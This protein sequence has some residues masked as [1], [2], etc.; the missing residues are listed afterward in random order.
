LIHPGIEEFTMVNEAELRAAL[1]QIK[2]AGL[3]LLVH[4]ELPGP[5]E[6]AAQELANADWRV[7]ETFL[8]SRPDEAELAAIDLLLNLCREFEC[9]IHV[10]HLSTARALERLRDAKRGGL[11]ITVETCPHYLHLAAEEIAEGATQF[12]CA[13]P[14][15]RR[16]NREALWQGL[17][18]GVIDLVA[19]DHSPCPPPMKQLDRGDFRSAWGGIPGVSLAL[20]I[21]WTEARSRGFGLTDVAR[22]M[23]E[24]PARLAGCQ[25]KKGQLAAGFDADFVVFDPD[26]EWSVNESQLYYRHPVSPYLGERLTGRVLMTYLRGDCVFKEGV[27]PAKPRG[28]ECTSK[29]S[30]PHQN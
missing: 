20:P 5:V 25:E 13:P 23:A 17:R 6:A 26:A 10:V 24:G 9:C 18:D 29:V 16:E 2:D 14:I 22:W 28:R 19:T 7:Y 27:F 15:R 3:P 8:K 12:K 21:M 1:P 30:A 4:A 11:P